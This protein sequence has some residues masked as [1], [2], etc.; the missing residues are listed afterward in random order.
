R[1]RVED[2]DAD[3][4]TREADVHD[5][6]LRLEFRDEREEAVGD[7]PDERL[8]RVMDYDGTGI[9]HGHSFG[10]GGSRARSPSCS[11][12]P[13]STSGLS[14]RSSSARQS[15]RPRRGSEM[16]CTGW[17]GW[18]SVATG[19]AVRSRVISPEARVR[20]T[21][22]MPRSPGCVIST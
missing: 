8:L 13:N 16:S 20:V 3:R 9:G 11:T 4:A 2:A 12:A 22:W 17:P 14:L 5:V 19:S 7:R 6:L 10:V 15:R 18:V 21:P 1:D